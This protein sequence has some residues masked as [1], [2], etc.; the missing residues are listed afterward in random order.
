MSK[1]NKFNLYSP[2]E[3]EPTIPLKKTRQACALVAL[4]TEDQFKQYLG[5]LEND[6]PE[7]K[8]VYYTVS[9]GKLWVM[10]G[11]PNETATAI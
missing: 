7:A 8:I 11:N 3:Q 1:I 10:K 2:D 6:F 9:P 5:I 4:M